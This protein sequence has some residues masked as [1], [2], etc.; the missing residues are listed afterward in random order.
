MRLHELRCDICAH[1]QQRLGRR[2][3]D[4]VRIKKNSRSFVSSYDRRARTMWFWAWTALALCAVCCAVPQTHNTPNLVDLLTTRSDL[5]ILVHLLQRTRLVPTLNRLQELDDAQ[6]GLTLFAPTNA[7]WT[8]LKSDV[9]WAPLLATALDNAST[10]LPD[11]IQAELR[12]RLLYHVL[13]YTLPALNSPGT[14]ELHETL[15]LPS[16]KRLLEPTEPG[17]IPQPPTNGPLDEDRGGALGGYGQVV[18][19]V[20]TKSGSL[21][22]GVNVMG[23]GGAAVL[24]LDRSSSRGALVVL[25]RVLDVPPSLTSLLPHV[26]NDSSLF[27]RL[28]KDT[29]H[30]MAATPHLTMFLPTDA[31]LEQLQP[32]ERAYLRGPWPEAIEDRLR[33]FAWHA[34]SIGIGD[35]RVA[36]SARLRAAL[37]RNLTM[38]MG[39]STRI[40]AKGKV[41]AVNGARVVREDVLVENGVVHIVDGLHLPFGDLGL[42]PEK[43][44]LA[45]GAERF[46][47]LMHR[48]GLAHYI[49]QN[50][51]EAPRKNVPSDPL[52]L[53]VPNE[54]SL[55]SWENA[56]LPALRDMLQYHLLRGHQAVENLTRDALLPTVLQ[57][58]GLAGAAQ[59][60]PAVLSPDVSYSWRTPHVHISLGGARLVR[61]PMRANNLLVYGVDSVAHVPNDPIDTA[62]GT[63]SLGA[64]ASALTTAGLAESARTAGAITYLAPSNLAF[65]HLGLAAKYLAL[66]AGHKDLVSIME[67]HA[68]RGIVYAEKVPRSWTT[69]DTVESTSLELRRRS[70]RIDVRRASPRPS[71]V[72]RGVQLNV[73][74]STGVIH[75]IDRVAYPPSLNLTLDKL[76]SAA[77]V[78]RMLQLI[79]DTG[80]GWAVDG[81]TKPPLTPRRGRCG[82]PR[83]VLLLPNNNAFLRINMT[84]YENDPEALRLLV[85]QHILLVDACYAPPPTGPRFPLP[86][87]DAAEVH[88]LLDQRVGGTSAYGML[89]FRQTGPARDGDLG[90]MIGV[91]GARG[92]RA[93]SHAARVLN[94]GRT[95]DVYGGSKSHG[96]A[97]AEPAGI[98]TIDALIEPYQPSWFY[99][100]GWALVMLFVAACTGMLG[101][102]FALRQ[103]IVGYTRIPTEA[104]E[105]EEE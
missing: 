38:I 23:D 34:S 18:R 99:R 97:W 22:V 17:R 32:I 58:V 78:S 96:N 52:T 45:W 7:A 63:A 94:F 65:E 60:M 81:V 62:V 47:R 90:Y 102:V 33:F 91:R 53:I 55:A 3:H 10:P 27:L 19:I 51:H 49:N 92:V 100:W 59:P 24:A 36:Y 15:Y 4:H 93:Q 56:S 28:P 87:E 6:M 40:S 105:G 5:S 42:T 16:R 104:L 67:L 44:L 85:A 11:N 103:H 43:Y 82:Y 14:V 50:P 12:Q 35:G 2:A 31:A 79:R 61:G 74:T 70:G 39:G 48:A 84:A 101:L 68:V 20:R 95:Q 57:P 26:R 75:T 86:L 64:F 54:E 89:A 41:L 37:P 88:S 76:S 80:F 25:D 1:T 83:T 66:P 29:L 13:N 21:R 98:L 9:I 73:L 46:V 30:T 72:A 8:K 77:P 69:Y 71:V